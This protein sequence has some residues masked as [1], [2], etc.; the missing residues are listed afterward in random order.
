MATRSILLVSLL[1]AGFLAAGC[2]TSATDHDDDHDHTE[3]PL[4][5]TVPI[6]AIA[7][8]ALYVVNGGDSSI[9]VINT[10]TNMV[11]GTIRLKNIS[12]P[13]HISLTPDRSALLVAILG[14]DLSGGHSHSGHG[15]GA[16]AYLLMMDA[17]TGTLRE[18]RKL[19]HPAHNAVMAPTG[20]AI[21]A[22]QS[23]TAGTVLVLD[24]VLLGTRSTVS[25]GEMPLEVTLTPN[26]Q[27]AFVANNAS[28]N[29][30]VIDVV[31]K[32]IVKTI[33]V[34]DG[35]VGAWPGSNGVMYV[36]NET[37]K[38]V[39]A[40]DATTLQTIRTYNLGF[41]PAMATVAPDTTLWITDAENGK[42]AIFSTERDEK[43]GE[44]TVGAGT[45]GIAFSGDGKTAYVSNQ[46]AGTVSV[47]DVATR[48]VKATI[49]VG[50]KPNGIVW[51]K[52]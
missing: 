19:D 21:W 15:G 24:P 50:A 28:D 39:T 33:A 4:P 10:A 49:P 3:S 31:S 35:P 52:G 48:S 46:N 7:F 22:A 42:V 12:Y 17:T 37:G 14:Q 43:I 32:S 1:F 45:H 34:G 2:G 6:P 13:H 51:R 27:Y 36:D 26:G 25:V 44:I 29:V 9:S 5:E 23:A 18:S 20:N 16:A 47:I 11:A 30:T 8:D 40:I 41:T 38:T